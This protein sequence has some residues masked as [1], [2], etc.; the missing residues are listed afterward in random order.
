VYLFYP[1]TKGRALEDM[2]VLFGKS[3]AR[4]H[5]SDEEG[6]ASEGVRINPK[7]A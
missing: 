2:D 3:R 1:E 6:N 4:V 7:D 5:S